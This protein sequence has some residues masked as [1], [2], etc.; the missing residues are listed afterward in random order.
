MKKFYLISCHG[1]VLAYENGKITQKNFYDINSIKDLIFISSRGMD[2]Y[3]LRYGK[4]DIFGYD[5]KFDKNNKS[6]SDGFLE[7]THLRENIISI[8]GEKGFL[9]SNPDKS[10][11][12]KMHK[13]D[14]EEYRIISKKNIKRL[15]FISKNKLLIDNEIHSFTHANLDYLF[16]GKIKIKI[17]DIISKINKSNTTFFYFDGNFPCQARI[18]NPLFVYVVFGS[19]EILEQFKISIRSL[20]EIGHYYGDILIVSD[21]NESIFMDLLK[22]YDFRNV[23]I[24]KS[25][26]SDRL[27]FVGSRVPILASE[28]LN[29]YSPIF[30]LD[31]DVIV[32]KDISSVIEVS[33]KCTKISAQLEN[34]DNFNN[35]LKSNISVGS[36]L[37]KENG[38]HI[39]DVNGFNAG[40]IMVPCGEHFSNIFNISNITMVMLTK[41]NNR[42]SIPFYDQSVLNYVLY[43]FDMFSSYPITEFTELSCE[44]GVENA[45]FIHFFPDGSIRTLKMQSFLNAHIEILSKL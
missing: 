6:V 14:W 16:F 23:R 26:G 35:K 24:I 27:D 17:S 18:I 10:I 29:F 13:F 45:T 11:D 4:G 21:Q 28:D 39:S 37:F 31:A 30:Y 7:I 33:V 9:S 1:F 5:N 2:S 41:N 20:F 34:Y 19:G 42:D 38:F 12:T 8:K 44:H 22:R 32:N 36:T 3:Q 40:V 15:S 43:K 25:F